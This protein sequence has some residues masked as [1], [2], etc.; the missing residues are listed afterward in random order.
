MA[1]LRYAAR[2]RRIVNTPVVNVDKTLVSLSALRQEVS[3]LR[4]ILFSEEKVSSK[5]ILI[6]L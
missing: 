2:A 1:T 4:S 3:F 5:I 6:L